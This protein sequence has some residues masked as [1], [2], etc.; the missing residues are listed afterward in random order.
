MFDETD[1]RSRMV[2]FVVCKCL[3]GR[4][5]T[6]I[7]AR[8]ITQLLYL[9]SYLVLK[10]NL[11]EEI[12]VYRFLRATHTFDAVYP[13]AWFMSITISFTITFAFTSN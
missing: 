2:I 3:L 4:L 9:F 13:T 12:N 11:I 6:L 1:Q 5:T 10:T 8:L 7:W